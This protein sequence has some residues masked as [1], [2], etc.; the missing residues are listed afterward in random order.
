MP[1]YIELFQGEKCL[2]YPCGPVV[3]LGRDPTN[4]VPLDDPTVS[5]N[6]AL[7]RMVG[8]E[9]YYL[10][11]VGSRNGSFLNDRRIS[12]PK[13]LQSGD[14]IAIGSTSLI[15]HQ[16]EISENILPDEGLRGSTVLHVAWKVVLMTILVADIRGFTRLTESI[17]IRDLTEVM[18]Q[19]IELVE[20][21][22]EKRNG[23]VDKFIGDAV[24]A[25]WDNEGDPGGYVLESLRTSWEIHELTQNLGKK[26]L[27]EA[28]EL[29]VGVGIN[30]GEAALGVGTDNTALGDAVNLAFRLE[31]TT[32]EWNCDVVISESSFCHLRGEILKGREEVVTVRGKSV[33]T[34]VRALTFDE[35]RKYIKWAES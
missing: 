18:S 34:R 13:L 5:R 12:T 30:S 7:I 2:K 22:V 14:V 17:S 23:R 26:Y 25:V 11:D 6:H 28:T 1:A 29:Q 9:Q 8:R 19:W 33:P 10:I 4:T 16:D 31:S 20:K 15:F 35:V 21:A 24:M 27:P 3:A 32:K